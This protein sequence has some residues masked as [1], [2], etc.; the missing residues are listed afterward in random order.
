MSA[1]ASRTGKKGGRGKRSVQSSNGDN[2]KVADPANLASYVSRRTL[3]QRAS[4][5]TKER[6]RERERERGEAR[7][8]EI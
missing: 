5:R 7:Y 2:N 6:E 8:R 4:A 3:C 1:I